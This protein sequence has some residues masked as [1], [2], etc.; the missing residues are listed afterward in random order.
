MPGAE[1]LAGLCM[2]LCTCFLPKICAW[3]HTCF[4]DHVCSIMHAARFLFQ[5]LV[6][7]AKGQVRRFV[8]T[9]GPFRL[10]LGCDAK[11]L[12]DVSDVN[13]SAISS[14]ESGVDQGD[15]VTLSRLIYWSGVLFFCI[16]EHIGS[17]H[18]FS[19]S[20]PPESTDA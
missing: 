4:D 1:E 10:R 13:L 11:P 6:Q 20:G 9:D 12:G 16:T 8:R 7:F 17:Y 15:P 18:A 19:M 14:G 5:Y 2:N 3:T